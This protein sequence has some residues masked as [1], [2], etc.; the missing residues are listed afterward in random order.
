MLVLTR[1]LQ[2]QIK[3]GD[4]ITV[5]ILRVKGNS[6]RIGVQAPRDGRVIRGELPKGDAGPEEVPSPSPEATLVLSTEEV[7]SEAGTEAIAGTVQPANAELPPATHLP[8]RKVRSRRG[9]GPLKQMVAAC[10]ALA[11]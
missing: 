6:V 9:A 1:K 5:T 11:K 2:Q 3:I 4:Q 7:G 10:G 8:L